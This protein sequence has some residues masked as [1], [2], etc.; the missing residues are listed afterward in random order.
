MQNFDPQMY[1][2]IGK[3]IMAHQK[4]I[5]LKY[6]KNLLLRITKHNL[7]SSEKALHSAPHYEL[8]ETFQEVKEA[9]IFEVPLQ[10]MNYV[11]ERFFK[12]FKLLKIEFIT[13]YPEHEKLLE[14]E[15]EKNDKQ[16]Q[17]Y[18]TKKENSPDERKK[19]TKAINVKEY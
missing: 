8:E 7:K 4:A 3:I 13:K 19:F 5:D 10:A 17:Q 18:I 11:D 1:I 9:R 12:H 15:L 14:S 2:E 6:H 16:F